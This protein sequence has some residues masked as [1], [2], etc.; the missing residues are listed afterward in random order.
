MKIQKLSLI[1][2]KNHSEFKIAG[3]EDV[4]ALAGLNGVGKTSVLDA[5]HFLCLGKSY[6][7]STDVQCIQTNEQVAGIIATID[8]LEH[9]ELKV[10]LKRGGRKSLEKNGVQYKR[11]LEHIGQYLAVVIAPGDIELVYGTNEKRRSFVNQILG[12][13]DRGHLQMLVK[14]NK[15]IEHRN[16]HLK[17]EV[18]DL[19]L[20]QTLD[21]QVAPLAQTI[22][23]E[24]KAFLAN[25]SEVFSNKYNLLS[26][27]KEDAKLH[28]IS[29]LYNG[30]YLDI[31]QQNR[32][33]DLAVQRSFTGIH[34][35]ELEI[36]LGDFSL[37][38][39]GSQGQIKSALIA[40][41]LAEFEYLK[42]NT[43]ITPFLL[44]DDIFEK[45]DEERAQVLTQIIK[46]DNF[47]QIF[48]T[49]TNEGRLNRFCE[50][51]GKPY[52]TIIL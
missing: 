10:K 36:E 26:G 4:I 8:A 27:E 24:R 45:I 6:F 49:D 15:L 18:V 7:S 16:K 13:V 44:L 22:Y 46:N 48:I 9:T 19:A 41:K 38:K 28:Y 32:S 31:V 37:K 21:D 42:T 12:Q 35:D 1:Y 5:I 34:K 23:V 30:S 17:Q 40:L 47:G 11:V 39:Y 20:I 29:Q 2:F 14:Y 25:F 52:K 50:E 3:D 33:K 43:G 51:I